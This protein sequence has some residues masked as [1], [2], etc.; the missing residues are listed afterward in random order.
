MKTPVPAAV[1]QHWFAFRRGIPYTLLLIGSGLAVAA[2]WYVL[3]TTQAA[4]RAS[5]LT[6]AAK[7]RHDIQVR[8]NSRFDVLRATAALLT[9]NNELNGAEFRAFVMALDLPTQYRGLEGIG[10]ARRLSNENLTSFQRLSKLDGTPFSI[11]PPGPRPDYYPVLFLEPSSRMTRRTI[12]FDVSTD[13]MV[14]AALERA[15]DTG[16]PVVSRSVVLVTSFDEPQGSTLLF[17]VPTYQQHAPLVTVAERRRAFVGLVLAHVSMDD[18]LHGVAAANRLAFDVYDGERPNAATV[19][20]SSAAERRRVG[21]RSAES[22][23]VAGQPWLIIVGA[24]STNVAVQAA[25]A[26]LGIGLLLA[27]LMFGLMRAQMRGWESAARHEADLQQMAL[28]DALTSLPNRA[29]LDDHLAK[30]ISAADR[31]RRRLAILFLDVD[32]FKQINDAWGHATGDELLRS[33]AERLQ[34]SVRRSDTVS[35]HGGDEFVLLLTDIDQAEH[36]AD[37]A[38]ELLKAV[39][40]PHYAAG[41]TIDVTVSAGVSIYPDDGHEATMLLLAADAAMYQAKER[42]RNMCQFFTPEMNARAIARQTIEAGLRRALT[43][44]ELVLHYQ[45]KISLDSGAVTGVEALVRWRD[46]N[47]GLIGPTEFVPIAEDSGLIVPLGRWAL[48]EACQQA[49]AWFE[50][51]LRFPVAVNV[52]AIE[53]RATDY[54]EH[55]R[56]ILRETRLDP[57]YLELELTESVLMQQTRSTVDV[58]QALRALGVTVAIDD[59]GTGYSSVTY[60]RQFPIDVLKVDQS[61]V[62]EI[63]APPDVS[64]IVS[65]MI[66]MGRSLGHRVIAEGVET[67]EQCAFLQAQ[68]CSEGQGFYF[69][70]PLPAEEL[71]ASLAAGASGVFLRT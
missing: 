52:S 63:T 40:V 44:Q 21:Y 57:H 25:E 34:A 19:H 70:R 33:V 27:F 45:P 55:A 7:T 6:D 2:S 26:T 38:H 42:G 53:L 37:R 32:R 48:R 18:L 17:L 69:S 20:Y 28:H 59:F 29:L 24:P 61:F 4:V 49:R 66:S 60:L 65:A 54:L 56:E 23:L 50:A 58:L 62:H 16:Q 71:A 22:A 15:R 13:G 30:A 36:A 35:R 47:R 46:P 10:F 1:A 39:S 9:A 3:S 12:G 41:H 64:P 5:F 68:H 43:R 31:H 67:H 11:W 8:L 51:G 14:C